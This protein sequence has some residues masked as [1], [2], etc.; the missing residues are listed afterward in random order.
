MYNRVYAFIASAFMPSASYSQLTWI[1]W[2]VLFLLNLKSVNATFYR[3][4][5]M[6][7]PGFLVLC[8]TCF[9]LQILEKVK[10]AYDIPIVTD[11]HEIEQ[12]II[13][14]PLSLCTAIVTD[15]LCWIPSLECDVREHIL[16]T[17]CC[18]RYMLTWTTS[19]KC[20]LL[21]PCLYFYL[22]A[23][24]FKKRILINCHQ[25]YMLLMHYTCFKL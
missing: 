11:V 21:L 5:L 8:I 9:C 14:F 22:F 12:V 20:V 6:K 17:S 3:D 18:L 2:M 4:Q 7:F 24:W 16:V 10:V 25:G 23:F 19:F 1:S 13:L 15:I